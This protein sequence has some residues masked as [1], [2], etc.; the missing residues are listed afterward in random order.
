MQVVIMSYHSEFRAV[1]FSVL[2]DYAWHT[3]EYIPICYVMNCMQLA[4]YDE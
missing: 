1:F 3:Y 4:M 2:E